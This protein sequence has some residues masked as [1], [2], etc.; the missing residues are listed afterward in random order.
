MLK[1][2]ILD[3]TTPYIDC[4]VLLLNILFG[5]S[6]YSYNIQRINCPTLPE[7]IAHCSKH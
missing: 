1:N 5:Q 7:L 3:K 6:I 2:T 4:D